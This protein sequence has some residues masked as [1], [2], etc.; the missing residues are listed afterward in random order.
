MMMRMLELGGLKV[1]Y[2]SSKNGTLLKVLRNPYGL[3]ESI[4][5]VTKRS[6]SNT[7]KL[8]KASMLTRVPDDYK[9]IYIKRSLDEIAASWDEAASR[10]KQLGMPIAKQAVSMAEKYNNWDQALIGREGVLRIEYN[11]VCQDPI[12]TARAIGLFIDTDAFKFDYMTAATAVDKTLY[13][14]R[15]LTC[16]Q[17]IHQQ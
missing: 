11:E 6:G 13:I 9:V 4:K 10:G 7:F 1:D 3:Y 12:A 2:A 16:Q 15:R 8:L 14:D 17:Y 5:I